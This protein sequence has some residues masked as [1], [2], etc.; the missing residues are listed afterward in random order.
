MSMLS[1]PRKSQW[2][3]TCG[4]PDVSIVTVGSERLCSAERC[5]RLEEDGQQ[6]GLRTAV[7]PSRCTLGSEGFPGRRT[8]QVLEKGRLQ[9]EVEICCLI[10][11]Q[12]VVIFGMT[13]SSRLDRIRRTALFSSGPSACTSASH[14]RL[15]S[16]HQLGVPPHWGH[17]ALPR[18]MKPEGLMH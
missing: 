4:V 17:A 12:S 5:S 14:L 3:V 13:N 8:L 10:K 7:S 1:S 15:A 2:E 11:D 18:E 6:T 16:G 9:M